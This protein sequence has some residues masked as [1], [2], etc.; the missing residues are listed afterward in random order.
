MD[1]E[2][3]IRSWVG[4]GLNALSAQIERAQTHDDLVVLIL[5]EAEVLLSTRGHQA[6]YY[7]DEIASKLLETFSGPVP[8]GLCPDFTDTSENADAGSGGVLWREE[9]GNPLTSTGGKRRFTGR[10]RP[11][12]LP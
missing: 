10:A 5:P 3:Y 4:E 6:R 1:T 9:E 7:T 8:C 11:C 2:D 12:W